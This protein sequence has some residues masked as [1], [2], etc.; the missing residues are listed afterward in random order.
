MPKQVHKI[1]NFAGGL[2]SGSDPRDIGDDQLANIEGM[3]VSDIGKMRMMGKFTASGIPSPDA[4]IY[5][6]AGAGSIVYNADN[7]NMGAVLENLGAAET[8]TATSGSA[9]LLK[10]SSK[11]WVTDSLVGRTIIRLVDGT[12]GP[13]FHNTS[14]TIWA[15]LYFGWSQ[16]SSGDD[17]RIT[18]SAQ[19][20]IAENYLIVTGTNGDLNIYE[21]T[22]DT[23]YLV[24]SDIALAAAKD[25]G[26]FV[27]A[28]EAHQGVATDIDDAPYWY[29]TGRPYGGSPNGIWVYDYDGTHRLGGPEPNTNTSL[30]SWGS[31]TGIRKLNSGQLW[32]NASGQT[33]I[34]GLYYSYGGNWDGPGTT[35][36]TT[37]GFVRRYLAS[38]LSYDNSNWTGHGND[39]IPYQ[40]GS[41]PS[42]STGETMIDVPY[43]YSNDPIHRFMGEDLCRRDY[44][45]EERWWIMSSSGWMDMATGGWVGI[46]DDD[47][48]P[49]QEGGQNVYFIFPLFSCDSLHILQIF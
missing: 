14:S 20:Q 5:L 22:T 17:Y 26:G 7:N 33:H 11:N 31:G 39:S 24:S 18:P 15:T 29:I 46:Y 40:G 21:K 4:D 28:P 35:G 16:W 41:T 47:F 6:R 1:E 23:W 44:K 10:D 48:Q 45:G 32:T 42:I 36:K 8:G 19:E 38:N 9:S 34:Y 13:I 37:R 3:S 2:S 27:K 49:I 43:G 25:V 12:S 30:L